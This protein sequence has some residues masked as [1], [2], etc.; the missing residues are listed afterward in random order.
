M[1]GMS[2]AY[3]KVAEQLL[4]F[5]EAK[6]TDQTD[7]TLKVPV[8]DYL[9]PKRWEREVELIFK[10]LPLMLALSI[11][12]PENGDYKAMEP[13]GIPV[14][15]TRGKD[16]AARAF[17][18]VCKHRAMKIM[19]EGTGNCTRI[20]CP[21]HGWT[22][23]NDGRLVGITEA[24]TFGDVDKSGL[25]LTGL[26]CQ[27]VAGMIFVI[28]TP[29]L[30]IDVPAFLGGM[31]DD[32]A[33]LRLDTWYYLKSRKMEGA[34]WKV[35]YDGYLEGYH[36]Q[37]AHPETVLPRTPSN[38]ALYEAFGPHIRLSYPQHRIVDLKDI[39]RKE[40]GERENLNYD[41]IRL[42]FPNFA[43]FLAPEMCQIAQLFPG[44]RP[45][46]NV[47]IMNYVY[48][49]APKDDAEREDLDKMSDFFFD[50]VE[51]EDYQMGLRVQQGLEAGATNHVV[52]GR[53][54]LGNQYFHKWI[55]HCLSGSK[56][57]EPRLRP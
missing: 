40:W 11:E 20:A 36:F 53:N 56:G 32:L 48:P 15:I 46:E 2:E 18:N 39:P 21:Y 51:K 35:A 12:L 52:F 49:R 44:D 4:H 27:E 42:V 30:E 50:V 37:A 26:P 19:E 54:E 9:D 43:L 22:Y 38:R 34:N 13:M 5:V 10:R 16:G 7:R 24:S 33:A 41:F 29:G 3:G 31:L 1:S 57:P 25:G 55:E 6:T 8:A 23:A 47:T 14:L 45:G 17:L 28:L